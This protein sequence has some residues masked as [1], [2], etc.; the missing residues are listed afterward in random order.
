MKGFFYPKN[1]VVIGVSDK[2]TN[3]GRSIVNNMV[4]WGFPGQ[5]HAVGPS[6]GVILGRPIRKSVKEIPFALDLAV[7]LTPAATVPAIVKECGEVGI[8]RVVIESAGFSE[9]SD[10]KRGLEKELMDIA[11]Q[12]G[13]RFVGPNCIGVINTENGL[14]APFPRMENPTEAGNVSIVAQSGGV[15][16]SYMESLAFEALHVNKITSM[17]NKLNVDESDLL[18]YLVNEDAGTQIICM[19]LEGFKTARRFVEIARKSQKP[20]ILHKAGVGEAGAASAASH[21]GAMSS[22]DKVV[23]AALAQAGVIRVHKTS[24]MLDYIKVL[25][26]PPLKGKNIAIVSRSGGHG[27]I[28]ADTAEHHG[29]N[30]PPFPQEEL[31]KISEHVRGGVINLRNPMD[32]G[33]LFDLS[34]YEEV[35]KM[36]LANPD[37]DGMVLVHSYGDHLR[38]ESHHFMGLVK[39]LG[40][41]YQKP[42]A[43]SLFVDDQ[44]RAYLKQNFDFPIFNSPENAAAALIVSYRLH[45]Y[46]E[47][48]AKF[49]PFQ[50]TVDTAPV[51]QVIAQAAQSGRNPSQG[52]CFDIL[53]QY[54]LPVP[55]YRTVQ[56]GEAAAEAARDMG[57]TVVLKVDVPSIIHKSDV[58][59][60]VLNLDTPQ[61]A[62]TA[63]DDMAHRLKDRL[64]P[65]EPFTALV[66]E[67]KQVDGQEVIFGVKQDES[68]GPTL[69][70]GLGGVFAELLED[71]SLRV[72][73]VS[74]EN[75][76]EMVREIKGYHALAGARG[77]ASVNVENIVDNL[78]S[79]SQLATDL[80]EIREIDLNPVIVDEKGCSVLDVRF[81]L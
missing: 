18:D 35:A 47:K 49:V 67:Q 33:D 61:A 51:R 70:F 43:M 8:R 73:P 41:A 16:I 6:A 55:D 9:F 68:F 34:V 44:E 4:T 78:L 26:L 45:S 29:F 58:G 62:K 37:I 21:T 75:V 66:M 64:A 50:K 79:L 27:V 56:T 24:Q 69:L 12:Y 40:Q 20:I 60:V 36:V 10:E 39:E 7:I 30:L 59:G 17:G 2:P 46:R 76:S 22:D 72:L 3:M 81:I 38:K 57:G 63:F 77:K 25:K 74:R 52:E 42:V 32:L 13:I 54:G 53:K 15:A 14:C 11:D 5:I 1:V 48:Q 28:A 31:D 80:P 23:S 71:V 65:G 19:Y